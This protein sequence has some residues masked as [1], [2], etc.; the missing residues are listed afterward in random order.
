MALADCIA[1]EMVAFYRTY[2]QWDIDMILPVPLSAKRFRER[3]YNQAA[4]FALPLA[5][6]L[7]VQYRPQV[8]RRVRH[9]ASQVNLSWRERQTNVAG[10][11]TA[12]SHQVAGRKVMLIDDVITTGAT[13]FACASALMDAGAQAVYA[14]S[15]AR[16]PMHTDPAS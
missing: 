8:I 14:L 10:A 6:A 12:E 7:E 16:A 5:L 11:F 15:V 1:A 9:T 4:L 3:G 13:I 2:V